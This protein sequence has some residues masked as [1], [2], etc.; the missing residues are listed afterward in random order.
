MTD[1][2]DALARVADLTDE[3]DRML[4]LVGPRSLR[5]ASTSRRSTALGADD[6]AVVP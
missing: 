2:G 3:R 4:R 6:H 5:S 1:L